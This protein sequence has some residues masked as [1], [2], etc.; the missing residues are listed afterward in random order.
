MKVDMS[1]KGVTSRLK[2]LE[3]L[4]ELSVALSKAKKV[5]P[6]NNASESKTDK[7]KEKSK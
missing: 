4:W 5:E 6:T 1:S 2:Q 3:Q 7:P